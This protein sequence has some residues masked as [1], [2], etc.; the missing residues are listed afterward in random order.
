MQKIEHYK[1]TWRT[2][3]DSGM[4]HLVL[5]DGAAVSLEI[6][7]AAEASFLLDLL[8]NEEQV[9]FDPDHHLIMTGLDH[10]KSTLAE[11]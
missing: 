8:R 3:D 2:I 10:V 11:E 6:D 4:V 7:S 9:F 1:F 5:Q